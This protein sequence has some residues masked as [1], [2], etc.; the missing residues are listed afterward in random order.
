MAALAL[1]EAQA[2]AV[3]SAAWRMAGKRERRGAPAR[4]A[5]S[6]SKR[7]RPAASMDWANFIE[8]LIGVVST[9]LTIALPQGYAPAMAPHWFASPNAADGAIVRMRIS[10]VN[11]NE[12]DSHQYYQDLISGF[13]YCC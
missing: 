6:R 13:T 7:A 1:K 5:E 3:Q 11:T 9:D 8:L 4:G 10:C 12:N 2:K